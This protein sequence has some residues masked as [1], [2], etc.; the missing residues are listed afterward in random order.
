MRKFWENNVAKFPELY[1][2]TLAGTGSS[3]SV[4]SACSS[5]PKDHV[6]AQPPCHGPS[7]PVIGSVPGKPSEAIRVSIARVSAERQISKSW[8]GG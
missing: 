2:R 1:R 6:T 5:G 8:Q 7:L 4:Q 3:E